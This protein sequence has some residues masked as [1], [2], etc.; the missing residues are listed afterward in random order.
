MN[1]A[2]VVGRLLEALGR[3]DADAVEA[4]FTEEIDWYVGGN[5]ALP[6]TG[7]RTRRSE[8]SAYFRTLWSHLVP[9]K[10]SSVVKDI[11]VSGNAAVVLGTFK[12]I[13][14][15]TGI[16][17]E[18]PIALHLRVVDGSITTLHLYE[19]TWLVSEAFDQSSD[20]VTVT[21]RYGFDESLDRLTKAIASAGATLF[22]T[23][24]QRAAG[25]KAGIELRPTTL[26]IF[27]NPALGTRLMEKLP[28]AGLDLPLKLLVWDD[29]GVV[30]V[31]YTRVRTFRDPDADPSTDA[32]VDTMG[33]AIATVVR[34]I[35]RDEA[36]QDEGPITPR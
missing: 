9:G 34:A 31:A 24:D 20:V 11:V 1:T 33:N 26:L 28:I 16:V 21:S 10:S 4:L 3:A 8:V 30:S 14:K 25:A 18:M 19:D 2:D 7:T 23:I 29:G 13:A 27:G 6:W 15:S 5:P 36:G 35:K 12:N 32:I 17:F 22:A